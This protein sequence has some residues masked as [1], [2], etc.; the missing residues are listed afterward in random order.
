MGLTAECKAVHQIFKYNGPP[1][2]G[3]SSQVAADSNAA[4]R[5]QIQNNDIASSA[6]RLVAMAVAHKSLLILR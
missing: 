5:R 3:H 1:T 4:T 6:P 2:S